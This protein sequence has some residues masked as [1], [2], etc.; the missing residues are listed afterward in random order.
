MYGFLTLNI[1]F[2]LVFSFIEGILRLQIYPKFQ[3]PRSLLTAIAYCIGLT[4]LSILFSSLHLEV[5]PYSS[6]FFLIL[7]M[8]VYLHN[9]WSDVFFA[10]V[11]LFF[12]F[13]YQIPI[14]T[15]L[16]DALIFILMI[17]IARQQNK[18]NNNSILFFFYSSFLFLSLYAIRRFIILYNNIGILELIDQTLAYFLVGL[19]GCVMLS[20]VFHL[21]RQVKASFL[22]ARLHHL[23]L[24]H[25][26]MGIVLTKEDDTMYEIN[27]AFAKE[28]PKTMLMKDNISTYFRKNITFFKYPVSLMN[29]IE[30]RLAWR[31]A[32]IGKEVHFETG[33]VYEQ[34][35][36]PLFYNHQYQGSIWLYRDVTQKKQLEKNLLDVNQSLVSLSYLDGLTRVPNRR[37]WD[38]IVEEAAHRF[39]MTKRG[40]AILVLDI[41]YFKNYNDWYGHQFGDVALQTI[42]KAL[43]D[44]YS[45]SP[46]MFTRYGGEEFA[47]LIDAKDERS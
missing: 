4:A 45:D 34:D 9:D 16:I 2:M 25:F 26:Q 47:M 38:L 42:A 20:G 43:S 19:G 36:I 12:G 40:Y 7:F 10:I 35:Y 5:L 22:K 41:D 27:Q 31:T 14:Q 24:E 33:K 18:K 30:Q 29:S 23:I 8:L 46:H 37:Y 3:I 13:M 21:L 6:Y 39:R 44:A 32:H 15:L 1:L 17:S 28:F 11:L